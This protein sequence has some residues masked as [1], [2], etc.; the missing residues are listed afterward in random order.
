MVNETIIP[1]LFSDCSTQHQCTEYMKRYNILN[2]VG[3]FELALTKISNLLSQEQKDGLQ[4]YV[5]NEHPDYT[6]GWDIYCNILTVEQI[7]TVGY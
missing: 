6:L 3:Y 2:P 7:H 4:N 5:D 1:V